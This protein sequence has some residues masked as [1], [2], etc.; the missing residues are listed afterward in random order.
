MLLAKAAAQKDN[1]RRGLPRLGLAQ[2]TGL[3]D[4]RALSEAGVQSGPSAWALEVGG[5]GGHKRALMSRLGQHS[6]RRGRCLCT[7]T[8]L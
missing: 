2:V 5:L 6:G 3:S 4:P 8:C 1:L 7:C